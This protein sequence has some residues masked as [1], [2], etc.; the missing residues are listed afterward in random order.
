MKENNFKNIKNLIQF[1]IN[2]V[3]INHKP[4]LR[5][6][7]NA[8]TVIEYVLLIGI[9][10][11]ALVYMGTD[12][13]RGLQSVVKVTA[14]QLGNQ[15]DSDQ[16]SSKQTQQGFLTNSISNSWQSHQLMRTEYIG[17]IT[18]QEGDFSESTTNSLSN[19]SFTN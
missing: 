15:A 4:T 8:Q 12:F 16:D 3:P 7:V 10:T 2:H 13:K 11:M 5:R 18:T 14:D 17:A 9:V 6:S 19:Q 1:T